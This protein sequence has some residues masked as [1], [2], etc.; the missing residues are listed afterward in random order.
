MKNNSWVLM[1]PGPVNVTKKVRQALLRPDICH[2][3]EEFYVLLRQVREKL[4]KIFGIKRSHTVAVMTGSGTLAV[5]AMIASL[6]GEK[7][8]VL[9]NGVYGDRLR[10]ILKIH[11]ISNEILSAKL[12]FFP[13]LTQIEAILKKDKSI[14]AVAMVHHETSTGML[15]PLR[16]VGFLARKYKKTFVVDAVSSLGA[17]TVDFKK[18]GID[19]CAGSA[20]KCLHAYPGVCFV[21]VSKK[22]RTKLQKKKQTSLYMNLPMTLDAEDSDN[23][24][25]TPAV[26]LFYALD[27]ALDELKAE[28][29]TNRIKAYARKARLLEKGFEEL[30]IHFVVGEKYRSHALQALWLPKGISYEKLHAELKKKSFVIYAGQ[31]AL[32]N[33]IFRVAHLGAVSIAEL[34][35]FLKSFRTILRTKQVVE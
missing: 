11:N 34:Q 6:R 26:Q 19:L 2:R 7:V 22:L 23:P 1:N 29:L 18:W 35:L 8:L 14:T 13:D 16:E 21:F 24:P 17:E 27:A 30:G 32:K 33:S 25:F 4:L 9:S 15:N 10:D 5:E 12:G 3:E 31:S 20:G 28:G